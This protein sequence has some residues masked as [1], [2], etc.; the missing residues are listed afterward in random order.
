MSKEYITYFTQD[1]HTGKATVTE[2]TVSSSFCNFSTLCKRTN[3][4]NVEWI[5]LV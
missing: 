5:A 2:H 4:Y 1:T 3:L